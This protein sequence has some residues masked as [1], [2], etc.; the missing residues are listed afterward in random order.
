MRLEDWIACMLHP[1]PT[2]DLEVPMPATTR[3]CP[4]CSFEGGSFKWRTLQ[5]F[6]DSLNTRSPR[7]WTAFKA[8]LRKK[9]WNDSWVEQEETSWSSDFGS[10]FL[11]EFQIFKSRMF[12]LIWDDVRLAQL[13]RA[14]D[15]QSRGSRFDSGKNTKTWELKSTCIWA[16]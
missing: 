12:I 10:S 4:I 14:Q 5:R 3:C 8:G 11:K 2:S 16:T 9:K 6:Q 7:R 15:C 1:L 13:A